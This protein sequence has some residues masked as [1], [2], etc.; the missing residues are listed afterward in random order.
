MQVVG[1]SGTSI[2]AVSTGFLG[3]KMGN[4]GCPWC[5]Q[6]ALLDLT[7]DLKLSLLLVLEDKRWTIDDGGLALMSF[8]L[9][10]GGEEAV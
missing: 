1:E 2:R 4:S 5:P 9:Q 8:Q 6:P 10:W 3:L 7:Q